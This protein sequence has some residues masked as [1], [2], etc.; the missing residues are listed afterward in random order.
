M[1]EELDT[2]EFENLE[3]LMIATKLFSKE[4]SKA[5]SYCIIADDENADAAFIFEIILTIFMEGV[6]ILYD[7]LTGIDLKNFTAEHLTALNPWLNSICFNLTIDTC[8]RKDKDLYLDYYCKVILK[9]DPEWSNWFEHKNLNN[10]YYFL[11]N[12][13]YQQGCNKKNVNELYAVFINDTTVFKLQ[14]SLK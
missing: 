3:P 12:H 9:C 8:E 4:P 14:F 13:I 1:V 6:M 5:S 7:N 2:N 10:S 11:L